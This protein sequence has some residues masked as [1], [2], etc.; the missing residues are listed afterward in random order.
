MIGDR[1]TTVRLFADPYSLSRSYQTQFLFFTRWGYAQAL[2][3]NLVRIVTA[4]S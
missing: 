1:L 2:P 3:N 4:A